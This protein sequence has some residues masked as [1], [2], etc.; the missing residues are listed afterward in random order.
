[1]F[2]RTVEISNKAQLVYPL[3]TTNAFNGKFNYNNLSIE[4]QKNLLDWYMGF[5]Q[6]FMY[7]WNHDAI[8]KY[9]VEPDKENE[10][11]NGLINEQFVTALNTHYFIANNLISEIKPNYK[12]NDF[13]YSIEEIKKS[14][15]AFTDM[16]L[17]L[18]QSLLKNTAYYLQACSEM[19]R[20]GYSARKFMLSNA[21]PTSANDATYTKN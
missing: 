12:N 10:L 6:G 16:Q 21:S 17:M 8:G 2:N 13:R 1:M 20:I 19:I 5:F 3:V 15:K 11:L 7:I 14:V 4:E 9:I 18:A